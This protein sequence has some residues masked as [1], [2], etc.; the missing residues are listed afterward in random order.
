MTAPPEPG[1]RLAAVWFADI[2]GYTSLSARDEDGALAVVATFQRLAGET[3]E[4]HSGRIV[5]FIGDAALAEFASTDGA[6]RSALAL[7]ERFT[8][9]DDARRFGSTL[10]VGV[11][12]GEVISSPDGDIYGDGVNLAS[13]LQNQ[14]APGQVVASEAVHA[15]IRQRT[16]FRTEPLGNRAVKGIADP[17]TLYRVTLQEAGGAPPP[18]A[19]A[20]ARVPTPPKKGKGRAR[21]AVPA[22]LGLAAIVVFVL[23][24]PG[25]LLDGLLSRPSV[26]VT[27]TTYSVVEGG[28]EVGG[29]VTLAFTGTLDQATATSR[30]IQLLDPEGRPVPAEVSLGSDQ[31]TVVLDPRT[32]LAFGTPYTLVVGEDLRDSGNRPVLGPDGSEGMARFTIVTQPVPAGAGPATARLG[33][34]VDARRVPPEGPV[35]V[36]FTEPVDPRTASAGGVRLTREDGSPVEAGLVFADDNR[37]VRLEPATALERGGRY[38]VRIDSTL[39]TASGLAMAPD[40]LL[41]QVATAAPQRSLPAGPSATSTGTPAATGA[42]A[43]PPGTG[44]ATLN[45]TAVPAAALRFLKVVVDGDTLGPPPVNGHRLTEGSTHTITIVGVPDLSRYTLIVY[46]REVAAEAGKVL[47][48]TA[49]ITSFGSIDVVSTPSGVV[50]VDGRQVGRTPLTGYPVTAGVVHR[51]EVKPTPVDEARFAPFTSAFRVEPLEWKSLGRLALPPKG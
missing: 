48:I 7:M 36:R 43:G 27:G 40:T 34:A 23:L 39:T 38:A 10:R 20:E 16:V 12:V 13:R 25:G 19:P 41:F 45:L 37:E 4:Q 5:K 44:P 21:K 29:S 31:R 22:L 49:E 32:A 47:D 1:R 15:Q 14:A 30:N 33:D 51:L 8:E 2:V 46:R 26:R 9:S 42:P 6:I 35:P 11:N 3:V 50:L 17:V 24:D 18:P 28:M